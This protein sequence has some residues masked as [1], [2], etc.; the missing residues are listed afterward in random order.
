M[1]FFTNFLWILASDCVAMQWQKWIEFLSFE[2]DHLKGV[3]WDLTSNELSSINPP[4]WREFLRRKCRMKRNRK[5][6]CFHLKK[7]QMRNRL[8][9]SSG[10]LN[11]LINLGL[12]R[13][14][15][16]NLILVNYF[17]TFTFSQKNAAYK[18]S[19]SPPCRPY[20]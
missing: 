14:C 10:V 12:A 19:A 7:V 6:K 3:L 20:A 4:Q 11:P 1:S 16:Y 18:K 2:S 17:R 5:L 8:K 9:R 15:C 13:I